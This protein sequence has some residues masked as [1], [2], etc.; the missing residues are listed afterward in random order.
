MNIFVV[1]H[2]F[3]SHKINKVRREKTKKL[4]AVIIETNLT[5]FGLRMRSDDLLA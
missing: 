2:D 4:E 3:D 5:E 1:F